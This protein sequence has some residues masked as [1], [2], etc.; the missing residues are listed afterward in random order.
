MSFLGSFFSKFSNTSIVNTNGSGLSSVTL[1]GKTYHIKGNN[2]SIQ[3]NDIFVDG[4]KFGGNTD[5]PSQKE[6]DVAQK[7]EVH[8]HPDSKGNVPDI[9]AAHVPVTVHGSAKSVF[10]SNG[11]ITVQQ[12][13]EGNVQ[14]SNGEIKVGGNVGGNATTSNANIKAKAVL[15]RCSTSNGNIYL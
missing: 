6:I 4:V 9:T 1:N 14:T 11:L 10:N 8:I 5:E 2:I 15:S 12:N 7:I 3:N 13:V